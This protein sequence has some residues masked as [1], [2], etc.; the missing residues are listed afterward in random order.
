MCEISASSI[1]KRTGEA[2]KK[3]A[4]ERDPQNYE[5]T[6]TFLKYFA[7]FLF[8]ALSPVT[9][10]VLF[11]FFLLSVSF[12]LTLKYFSIDIRANGS[13][14]PRNSPR[15]LT[16]GTGHLAKNPNGGAA[17]EDYGGMGL[18][19]PLILLNAGRLHFGRP[20]RNAQFKNL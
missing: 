14:E 6:R 1:A 8:V 4:I 3:T 10:C 2:V 17:L 20:R 5:Q 13:L 18:A 7:S 11:Y 15:I 9:L 19:A 12:S 16:A